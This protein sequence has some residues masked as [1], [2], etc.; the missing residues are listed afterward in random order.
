MPNGNDEFPE[1]RCVSPATACRV[2]WDWP[3]TARPH[4]APHGFKKRPQ[5]IPLVYPD[6]PT[7]GESHACGSEEGQT[8]VGVIIALEDDPRIRRALRMTPIIEFYRYQI[9]FKLVKG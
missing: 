5:G 3:S 6:L 2:P 7:T 8:V 4:L 1:S 9:S